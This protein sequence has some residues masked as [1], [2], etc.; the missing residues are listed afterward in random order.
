MPVLFATVL[1]VN[2]LLLFWV[3]PLFAKM[4]L[5]LLGGSPSVW[6]TCM[7][8]FQAALLAG[9]AYSHVGLQWLGA[10]RQAVVHAVILWLPLLVLPFSVGGAGASAAHEPV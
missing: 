1:F 5:P 3:Q 10:R 9:Y 2:A 7:L 4:V 6:T 8:F